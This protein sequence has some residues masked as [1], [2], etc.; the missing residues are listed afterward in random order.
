MEK[1]FTGGKKTK[2]TNKYA[3]TVSGITQVLNRL[4]VE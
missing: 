2:I 3:K 4:G 1:R